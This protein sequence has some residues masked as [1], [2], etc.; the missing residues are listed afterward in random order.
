MLDHLDRCPGFGV[1]R[2]VGEHARDRLADRIGAPQAPAAQSREERRDRP[3]VDPRIADQPL[4][5]AVDGDVHQPVVENGAVELREEDAGVF[6]LDEVLH[7]DRGREPE[8]DQP[9]REAGE[10][11]MPLGAGRGAEAR[12]EHDQLERRRQP[13]LQLGIVDARAAAIAVLEQQRSDTGVGVVIAVPEDMQPVYVLVQLV[14]DVLQRRRAGDD[15]P[16]LFGQPLT[17]LVADAGPA[18]HHRHLQAPVQRAVLELLDELADLGLD[19]DPPVLLE[20]G[21]IGDREQQSE[22]E[23]VGRLAVGGLHGDVA[24]ERHPRVD[25]DAPVVAGDR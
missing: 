2:Q 21:R 8:A 15:R 10:R 14:G 16:V 13:R 4:A 18:R 5:A 12:L 9:R 3:V 20:V 25:S 24:R 19:V 23:R 22:G 11:G 17:Q 1:G 7:G 6:H